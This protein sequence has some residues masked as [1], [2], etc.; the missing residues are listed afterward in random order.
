MPLALGFAQKEPML[1][2]MKTA[3]IS[4]LFALLVLIWPAQTLGETHDTPERL[5]VQARWEADRTTVFDASEIVM[6]DL[7]WVARP[8]VIFAQTPD[9]PLYHQQLTLLTDRID[10]LA[11]RDVIVITDTDPDDPSDLRLQL[12]PRGFMLAVVAKD[13][14]VALR[15]PAPWDVRELSRSIDKMPLR[16]QEISERR[17]M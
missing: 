11:L 4:K 16:Q 9:D 2:F 7:I 10:E 3:H 12:R 14:R 17:G 1:S 15:K 8:V 13:G 5:S 6:D